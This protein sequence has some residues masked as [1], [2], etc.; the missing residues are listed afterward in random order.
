M[1]LTQLDKDIQTMTYNEAQMQLIAYIKSTHYENLE[2]LMSMLNCWNTKL[3]IDNEKLDRKYEG[4][5]K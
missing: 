1:T 2:E 5:R 4:F 3:L